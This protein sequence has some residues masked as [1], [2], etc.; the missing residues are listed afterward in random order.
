MIKK[1]PV[2]CDGPS[3]DSRSH[4]VLAIWGPRTGKARGTRAHTHG[5]RAY[6]SSP[7]STASLALFDGF[8]AGVNGVAHRLFAGVQGVADAFFRVVHGF[9]ALVD[10]RIDR[11]ADLIADGFVGLLVASGQ[12]QPATEHQSTTQPLQLFHLVFHL[13]FGGVSPRGKPLWFPFSLHSNRLHPAV[14]RDR[15]AGSGGYSPKKI[16]GDIL[17][18]H[19]GR[20]WIAG[21]CRLASRLLQSTAGAGVPSFARGGGQAGSV[22]R[23]RPCIAQVEFVVRSECVEIMTS[24]PRFDSAVAIE[25]ALGD[26]QAHNESSLSPTVQ[27]TLH[28]V[29]ALQRRASRLQ[30]AAERKQQTELDRMIQNPHDKATLTQLT[31]QAFRSETPFRAADQLIHILD[32]QGVPRFFSPFERTLLKGFQS[33]GAYLPGVAVPLVKEKM[34]HETANVILPA[35][36][37]MLTRHLRAR[38]GEGVRMNVNYLGEA[39][40]GE[41]DARQRLQG[42]LQALQLPEIE[43][44]SVKISTIYSQI[45]PLARRHATEVLCDRLE[46]LYRASAKTKFIRTDGEESPKF[47]YMDMEEFRDMGVTMDA[48]TRTLDRP[49]LKDVT[50]GIVLQAYVPD[51]FAKQQELNAWA[52]KR[53]AAGGAPVRLRI[54]KGRTWR[55]SGWRLPWPVGRKLPFRRN[56]TRIATTSGCCMK[57]CAP[58]TSTPYI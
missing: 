7:P 51:A 24:Q 43:V 41:A 52:R 56:R 53:R 18:R 55:W 15:D 29:R 8:F 19:P 34:Q 50:A 13:S 28:L 16:G 58:K 48:F 31:D 32:A 23:S 37:E 10:R 17:G 6:L 42:Y 2:V 27:K 26:Y 33:F 3:Q 39:L 21:D 5:G 12:H 20:V 11:F 1:G 30:T 54:V 25:N 49:G 35:E 45:T 9:L 47:V 38:R 36:R 4:P 14:R 46:L 22:P 57:P 44:I 40:L